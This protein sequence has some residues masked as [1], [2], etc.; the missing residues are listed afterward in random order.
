VPVSGS[1]S[2]DRLQVAALNKTL[3]GEALAQRLAVRAPST[4]A[5]VEQDADALNVGRL[6][7]YGRPHDQ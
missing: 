1:T 3:R 6:L 5:A 2:P 4:A 7:C